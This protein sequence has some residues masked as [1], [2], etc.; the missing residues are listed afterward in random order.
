MNGSIIA[1]A[2]DAAGT[3]IAIFIDAFAFRLS[4]VDL[5]QHLATEFSVGVIRRLGH[6]SFFASIVIPGHR[7]AVKTQ[8]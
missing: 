3:T 8:R 2:I 6:D 7:E 5:R 1:V 4:G